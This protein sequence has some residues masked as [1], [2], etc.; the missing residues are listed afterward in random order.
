[1]RL[2]DLATAINGTIVLSGE[3]NGSGRDN[4]EI[5][6]VSCDSRYIREGEAFFC[7]TGGSLDGGDFAAEAAERG[8]AAIVTEKRSRC[9][10]PRGETCR[11]RFSCPIRER[12]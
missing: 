7:L 6:G 8:A 4:P 1:M 3:S 11:N 12:R 10:N 2:K 9:R 5:T